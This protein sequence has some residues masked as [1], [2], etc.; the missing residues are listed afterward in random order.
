MRK[1]DLNSTVAH[2]NVDQGADES[3]DTVIERTKIAHRKWIDAAGNE[4]DEDKAVAVQYEF[5]GRTK[6]GIVIPADGKSY[7]YQLSSPGTRTGMLEGFGAL[8]LMGNI[9]NTWMGDKGDKAPTAHDA[10]TERFAL[11]E[12]GVWVDRTTGVGARVDLDKLAEAIVNVA[13]R[14]GK[15]LDVSAIRAKLESDQEWRKAASANAEFKNE[16]S[17]LMGRAVKTVDELF[18]GL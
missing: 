6:A 3:S 14:K 18:A 13:T 2:S 7:T 10:I 15:S 12:T 16:Y 8:T 5:L 11:L 9:T 4:V 1:F 17:Q